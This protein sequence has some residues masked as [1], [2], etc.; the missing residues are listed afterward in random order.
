[1][2]S[3]SYTTFHCDLPQVSQ[4]LTFTPEEYLQVSY[5]QIALES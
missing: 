4:S 5:T 3:L 1:M 2:I